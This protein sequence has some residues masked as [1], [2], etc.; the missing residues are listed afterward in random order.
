VT[1]QGLTPHL[2]RTRR[3]ATCDAPS[4]TR[5]RPP[6][7]LPL[8]LPTDAAERAALLQALA[9][10]IVGQYGA[11]IALALAAAIDEADAER[12]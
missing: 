6:G 2:P 8:P 3:A 4:N 9:E 1:G 11:V 10:G 7:P 12:R 5:T